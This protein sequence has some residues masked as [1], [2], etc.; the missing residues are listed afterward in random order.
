MLSHARGRYTDVQI[1][2]C[3]KMGGGYGKEIDRLFDQAICNHPVKYDVQTKK[4]S[5]HRKDIESFLE[6]YQEE[7]L[8][9]YCPPR[10]HHG[11]ENYIDESAR[12]ERP[13]DL[14]RRLVKLSTDYD[15]WRYR[16]Q[17]ARPANDV[18]D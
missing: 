4:P 5:A 11:F 14:A 2:R 6:T 7:A 16:A 12:V 17:R 1:D 10:Q 18:N 3:S 8:F 15:F 9:D 13:T